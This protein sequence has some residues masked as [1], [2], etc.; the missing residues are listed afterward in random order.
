MPG[1]GEVP[2]MTDLER[3]AARLEAV[4]ETLLRTAKRLREM[5]ERPEEAFDTA[6]VTAEILSK[7]ARLAGEKG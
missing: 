6:E 4:A 1:V 3:E 2:Q 7:V 5:A